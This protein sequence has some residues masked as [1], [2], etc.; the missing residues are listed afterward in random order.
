MSKETTSN[1]I[2]PAVSKEESIL[3]QEMNFIQEEF[4]SKIVEL[5]KLREEIKKVK[6]SFNDGLNEYNRQKNA[7]IEKERE[8]ELLLSK[9]SKMKKLVYLS[10][11]QTINKKFYTHLL[12]I[13]SN[14][15]KEKILLK[16][17]NF[18]FGIYNYSKIYITSIDKNLNEF[19]INDIIDECLSI[20]ELLIIL[21]NE[22]EIRNILF[23]MYEIFHNLEEENQEL[24]KNLKNSF[25]QLFNEMDVGEKMYPFDFLMDY[26]KNIFSIIYNER[27]VEELKAVLNNLM[28]EKNKK[29]IEIKNIESI[30]KTYNRNIKIIS[31]Y[32]KALKTFYYRIKEQ[33]K[34]NN[35]NDQYTNEKSNI[36]VIKDLID[37]IEKFKKITL[38]YDK[39]NS[40]FD[41]MTSLSFGTNYTLSEKSS[42]KSSIMDSKNNN[43]DM[44]NETKS[45][46]N[47]NND[48]ISKDLNIHFEEKNNNKKIIIK[49]ISIETNDNIIK[50]HK[51]SVENK[52]INRNGNINTNKINSFLNPTNNDK[53]QITKKN[54]SL[55]HN[56]IFNLT[57]TDISSNNKSQIKKQINIKNTSDAKSLDKKGNNISYDKKF[58]NKNISNKNKK[59]NTKNN[60]PIK[61]SAQ[62]ILNKEIKKRFNS[63]N[64]KGA[65]KNNS[66]KFQSVNNIKNKSQIFEPKG[67]K[68]KQRKIEPYITNKSVNKTAISKNINI[69]INKTKNLKN[70]NP[71]ISIPQID[72]IKNDNGKPLMTLNNVDPHSDKTIKMLTVTDNITEKE[73]DINKKDIPP[74]FL[75]TKINHNQNQRYDLQGKNR[76]NISKKIE[77]LKQKENEEYIEITMSNK[78]NNMNENY[79]DSNDIKDSICDEMI[80]QNFGTANSLIKSTTNDYINRLGF[81]N[82]FLWSENLYKNKA[83]KFKS[84]FKKLNIEKPIDTSSCCAACT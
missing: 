71:N 25:L 37:D 53:R 24:F 35:N 44:I 15:L 41:A 50:F 66:Q 23:Y 34:N 21:K 3:K 39:L 32:V 1:N 29:F 5:K 11:N 9:V 26:I 70:P 46:L 28:K 16:I 52:A 8:I 58:K 6:T 77:Q 73:F 83:L 84:N 54:I 40:N 42:I 7:T 27:N 17:F 2:L 64:I 20:Q 51:K 18:I 38:D 47:E 81:K 74:I 22:N 48:K 12:E 78:E 68:S 65:A 60:L 10:L 59:F 4:K 14:K 57:T 13:S 45:E 67:N 76:Y 33:N 75:P 36:D 30:I 69:P 61:I 79:F 62:K 72:Q 82:N 55:M 80:T 31:N 63:N 56:N 49:N 19:N 43:D